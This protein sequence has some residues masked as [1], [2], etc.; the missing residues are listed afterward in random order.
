MGLFH[1]LINFFSDRLSKRIGI[2]L[3][4]CCIFFCVFFLLYLPFISIHSEV[5]VA[6]FLNFV[7]RDVM[8]GSSIIWFICGSVSTVISVI[9]NFST[10]SKPTKA[11]VFFVVTRISRLFRFPFISTFAIVFVVFPSNQ[12][13]LSFTSLYSVSIGFNGVILLE[14]DFGNKVTGD[15]LSIINLIGRLLTNAVRVKNSGPFFSHF[16]RRMDLLIYGMDCVR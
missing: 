5:I 4:F 13:R 15:P 7:F 14:C 1:E 11:L 9:P 3:L 12:I 10:Q 2:G 8:S 16:P 6:K